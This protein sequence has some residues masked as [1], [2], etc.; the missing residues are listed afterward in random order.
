MNETLAF[1]NELI[2]SEKLKDIEY[3]KFCLSVHKGQR[4]LGENTIIQRL[5][6]LRQLVID[7]Q[8]DLVRKNFGVYE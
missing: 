6:D 3:K 2:E 7:E 1:I 5:R 4:A 8:E